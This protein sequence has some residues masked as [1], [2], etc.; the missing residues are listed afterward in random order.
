MVEVRGGVYKLTSPLELT[1]GDSGL[2]DTPIIYHARKGEQGRL[3]GGKRVTNWQKVTDPAVLVRLDP[4]VRD[5]VWQADLKALGVTDYGSPVGGGLELFF[6]D[7]PMTLA[8]FP[9]EGF[10]HI[11]DI[12]EDDGHQIHGIKGSRVGRF[13]YAEHGSEGKTFRGDSRQLD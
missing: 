10:M 13:Y 4:S 9:N 5:K 11:A 7:A 3:L 2:P 6:N 12:A 8:R 1:K